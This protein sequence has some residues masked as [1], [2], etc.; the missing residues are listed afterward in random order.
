M[1]GGAYKPR[2]SPYDFQGLGVE[3]LHL[4]RE[5]REELRAARGHRGHEHGRRG[6]NLRARRYASGGS[7][8]HAEF[9]APAA[10][11]R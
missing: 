5:V 4:L 8:E 3:A 1:R 6:R 2:T 11:R 9:R 10:A 7:P